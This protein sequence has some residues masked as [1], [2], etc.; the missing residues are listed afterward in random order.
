MK[1]PRKFNKNL[2]K[3]ALKQFAADEIGL[4]Y[5][6]MVHQV[7]KIRT[8]TFMRRE[9]DVLDRKLGGLSI[10]SKATLWRNCAN[11]YK[12]VSKRAVLGLR[13]IKK[14]QEYVNILK[15]RSEVLYGAIKSELISTNFLKTESTALINY[16]EQ[17]AKHNYIR[18]L[19]DTV[20]ESAG[21]SSEGDESGEYT[22]FF[23]CSY[24]ENCAKDHAPYQGKIYYD[25]DWHQ[26]IPESDPNRAKI[27]AWIQNHQAKS[28]QWVTGPEGGVYMTTR[29][30][31]KHFFRSIPIE[32]VLSSSARKILISNKMIIKSVPAQ[33]NAQ[34]WT[35]SYKDRY[36]QLTMLWKVMPNEQLGNDLNTTRKLVKKWMK[37]TNRA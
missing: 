7:P 10:M 31:C 20:R 11:A 17:E 26:Y 21:S 12:K 37:L 35:E 18:D 25:E 5:N 15:N 4:I 28:L 36:D 1:N 23:I 32:A 14:D 3:N 29:P 33:T 9:L 13:K 24:H 8:L 27:E 30:N 34:R 16:E 2:Y 19:L 6:G 22:P